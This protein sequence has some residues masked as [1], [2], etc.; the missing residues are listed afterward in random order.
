MTIDNFRLLLERQHATENLD[1]I[2]SC[3]DY[4]VAPALPKATE[5]VQTYVE[6]GAELQVNISHKH[7]DEILSR[8]N[9]AEPDLFDT[10][11]GEIKRLLEGEQ[12]RTFVGEVSSMNLNRQNRLGKAFGMTVGFVV[13]AVVVL[14]FGL[15]GSFGVLDAPVA[16]GLQGLAF[17]PFYV[18]MSYEEEA[19]CGV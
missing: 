8:Q 6:E 3:K 9:A 17:F 15:L 12:Y 7:R 4:K 14:T 5:V 1:F 19:R 13:G 10:A 18:A 11:E 2:L 16:A